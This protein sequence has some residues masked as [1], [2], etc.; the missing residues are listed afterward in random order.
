MRIVNEP[1][2]FVVRSISKTSGLC[3]GLEGGV[4]GVLATLSSQS[5]LRLKSVSL[6]IGVVNCGSF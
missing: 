3:G 6:L 4:F 5:D 1:V 2:H